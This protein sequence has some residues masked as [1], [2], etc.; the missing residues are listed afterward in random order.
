MLQLFLPNHTYVTLFYSIIIMIYIFLCT[1]F[2]QVH[3]DDIKK[4]IMFFNLKLY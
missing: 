3:M 2:I 1:V 4:F